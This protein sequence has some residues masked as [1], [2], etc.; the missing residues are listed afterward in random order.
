MFTS[1]G[2][3]FDD[4][5]G[6]EALQ[7]LRYAA[8][9]IELAGASA[10]RLGA[11]LLDRLAHAQS[12]DPAV[13]NGRDLYMK[14]VKPRVPAPLRV[15]AGYA[16][17]RC[18]APGAAL[19][20]SGC[21]AVQDEGARLHLT[22]CR[23]G[24]EYAARVSVERRGTARLVIDVTSADTPAPTR[25][26]LA[27]LPERQ[28]LAVTRA[29]RREIIARRFTPDELAELATGADVLPHVAARALLRAVT[30]LERDQSA[31][32]IGA[33]SDLVDLLDLDNQHIPF[34]V[35]TEF[36][37]IRPQVPRDLAGRL[38][39]AEGD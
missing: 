36:Y 25:L 30:A 5:A 27:D 34:D 17:L 39:F 8:R 2:W 20:M 32:T 12:N 18:V 9:A 24:R 35:Q 11:G 13:G 14:A 33:V 28:R 6:I 1:C 16:A 4:I 37:R 22:H 21:Y 3:F 26:A 19:T 23:T 38:G 29:I 10:A 15:A 7:V 31:A